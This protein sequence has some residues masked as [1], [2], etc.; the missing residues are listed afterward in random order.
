MPAT[1]LGKERGGG[2]QKVRSRGDMGSEGEGA[3]RWAVSVGSGEGG[4]VGWAGGRRERPRLGVT[5][6]YTRRCSQPL[7]IR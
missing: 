2:E 4:C 3:Q 7:W 5:S 6:K 1:Q